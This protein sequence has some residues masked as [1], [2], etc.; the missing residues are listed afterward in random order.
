MSIRTAS[1]T[2]IISMANNLDTVKSH[3]RS[4]IIDQYLPGEDPE[5]LAD[6]LELQ[7]SGI[8]TSVNTLEL[9]DH[10]E[11]TYAISLNAHEIATR[12]N[13]IQNIAA[14]VVEKAE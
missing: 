13:S 11:E 6:D 7:G 2:T 3:L 12:L 8:L 1:P 14:L 9:V 5:N 10:I 4:R